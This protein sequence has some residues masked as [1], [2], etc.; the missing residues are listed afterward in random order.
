[1]LA[2]IAVVAVLT[3]VAV[4]G[5]I[6]LSGTIIF[7]DLQAPRPAALAAEALPPAP[8]VSGVNR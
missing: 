7:A 2:K 4:V 8:S 3:L 1:M 5:L 6:G